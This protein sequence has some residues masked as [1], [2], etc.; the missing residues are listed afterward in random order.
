MGGLLE[1]LGEAAQGGAD[2]PLGGL[3]GMLGGNKG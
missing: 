2:S 3:L 1:G